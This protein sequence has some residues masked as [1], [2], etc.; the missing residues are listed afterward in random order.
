M[1]DRSSKFG[2]FMAGLVFGAVA[3]SV[4]ALLSAP[5]SGEETRGLITD[6]SRDLRNKAMDT[7]DM[8]KDKTGK[9]IAEGRDKV[10][11]V[12]SRAK[13]RVDEVRGLGE[14]MAHDTREEL[15]QEMRRTANKVDP[16]L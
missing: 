1:S 9:V 12:V 14:D 10:E 6:K 11:T 15:S 16:N 4:I 3:G 8:A 5:Q 13:E 7:V 2:D